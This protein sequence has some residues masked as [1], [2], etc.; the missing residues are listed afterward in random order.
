MREA[1]KHTATDETR[2]PSAHSSIMPPALHTAPISLPGV[3]I[4]VVISDI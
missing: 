4:S 3:S 1:K 2:L